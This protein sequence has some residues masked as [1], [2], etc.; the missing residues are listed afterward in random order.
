MWRSAPNIGKRSC[1]TAGSSGY[2]RRNI[3]SGQHATD[4][5]RDNFAAY[6]ELALPLTRQIEPQVALSY[7]HYS[8]FGNTTNPKLGLKFKPTPE[9]LLRAN[10]GRGFRAPTL[11]E[12]SPSRAVFFVHG[13]RSRNLLDRHTGFGVF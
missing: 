9:V 3:G 1:K 5:S 6:A 7:D 4:A 11:V 2:R 8:D 10:W 13:Q 12:I